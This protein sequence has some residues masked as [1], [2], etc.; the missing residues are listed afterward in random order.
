M[1]EDQIELPLTC[2]I[3]LSLYQKLCDYDS[4][5][6]QKNLLSLPKVYHNNSYYSTQAKKG[7]R[8]KDR[9]PQGRSPASRVASAASGMIVK[10]W[11]MPTSREPS[12]REARIDVL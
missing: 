8:Y 9:K 12:L 1:K 3:T 7:V 6:P 10:S 2:M 11:Q 4:S 5:L